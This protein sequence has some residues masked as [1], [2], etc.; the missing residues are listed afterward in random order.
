MTFATP[1]PS[2]SLSSEC[3]ARLLSP[4]EEMQLYCGLANPESTEA[5]HMELEQE[6][7]SQKHRREDTTDD[8]PSKHPKPESG[9][10][11]GKGHP[12][13][14]SQPGSNPRSQ[15]HRQQAQP[16][17]NQEL[18]L[19]RQVIAALCKLCL[20][21]EDALNL[22]SLDT[23]LVL[24]CSNH[25]QGLPSQLWKVAKQ[26]KT[27]KE[28][29]KVHMSLRVTMAMYILGQIRQR[30]EALHLRAQTEDL[31]EPESTWLT[32]NQ[33]SYLLWDAQAKKHMFNADAEPVEHAQVIKNID[34][35]LQLLPRDN[36]LHRFHSLRPL[37]ETSD[38]PVIAFIMDVG[39]R[40]ESAQEAYTLLRTLCQL[41]VTQTV[42]M[43]LRPDKLQRSSLANH[44]QAQLAKLS[45]K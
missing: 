23:R 27:H 29:G 24:F 12:K 17:S 25:E 16:T 20:R 8:R 38:A 36:V 22:H 32:K 7:P 18:Q 43:N 37:T 31:E 6:N 33:W 35:L 21:H 45:D 28:A 39:L 1:P 5:S 44:I 34:R 9:A 11:K 30:A 42:S 40:A 14:R 4:T 10:G 3:P 26:W 41:S 2:L 13:A 19:L 15:A